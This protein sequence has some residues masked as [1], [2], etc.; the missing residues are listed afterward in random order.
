[1]HHIID[2]I[3]PDLHSPFSLIDVGAMGGVAKK[4][5]CIGDVLSTIA[6]EPNVHEYKKLENTSQRK[7]INCALYGESCDLNLNVAKEAAKT[8]LLKPNEDVLRQF[9]E[10]DRFSIIEECRIG[11]QSVKTLDQ[12]FL[13]GDIPYVDFL[14]C[15]TQGTELS[16]LKGGQ[17][18][19]VSSLWGLQV[20]VEFI[21]LYK[22]QPLFSDVHQ[23]MTEQGFY[24]M[25]FRRFF[26]KRS[27]WHDY[28][29]RGQMTF[30]DALYFKAPY[31]WSTL[32]SA[33]DAQKNK[34][35]LYK[36]L[37]VFLVY[38]SFDY[39]VDLLHFGLSAK[40]LPGETAHDL[41][42]EVKNMAKKSALPNF[43]GKIT[44]HKIFKRLS[45]MCR[46]PSYRGW[47]DCD[48]DIANIKDN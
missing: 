35:K 34:E 5:N 15:D 41:L 28:I 29:G 47:A 46:P 31:A 40:I 30:A 24:L 19:I 10:S 43:P 9:P 38:G 37:L 25:D 44:L 42:K 33:D 14:K 39:A 11:K 32:L 26:W 3:K 18:H 6:F 12:L 4:W 1:M 20:E 7:F 17:E 21:P 27:G 13:D 8:S 2:Y 16:I 23:F 22:D 45:W 48:T 36:G